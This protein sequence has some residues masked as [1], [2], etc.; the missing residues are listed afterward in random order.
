MR[1]LCALS[2]RLRSFASLVVD[3]EGSKAQ[4][5][6][7]V[8][9]VPETLLRAFPRLSRSWEVENRGRRSYIEGRAPVQPVARVK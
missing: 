5:S 7:A 9:T 4:L 8:G 6:A 1:L 2:A 3:L